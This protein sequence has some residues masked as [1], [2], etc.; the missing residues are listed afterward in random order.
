[1]RTVNDIF[2]N[3]SLSKVFYLELTCSNLKV[4]SSRRMCTNLKQ[5]S[6]LIS[7]FY[8]SGLTLNNTFPKNTDSKMHISSPYV[9]YD[10]RKESIDYSTVGVDYLTVFSDGFIETRLR[11]YQ[12]LESR[13]ANGENLRLL[14]AG[15]EN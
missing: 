10:L 11:V 4:F 2:L 14:T 12:N 7:L 5:K 9:I 3:R 8:Y 6:E 13:K 15:A 1:M